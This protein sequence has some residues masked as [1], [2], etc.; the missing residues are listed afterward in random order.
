[1]AK[2]ID[3]LFTLGFSG[4]VGKLMTF[5]RRKKSGNIYVGKRRGASSV[6]PTEE[7][8][9]RRQRFKVALAYAKSAILDPILKAAYA[10]VAGPDQSA[11]N[12]AF[13][14]AY[15]GPEISAVTTLNYLGQPGNTITIRATD[16]FKI[17]SVKVTIRTS[18]GDIIEQ[19][20][21]VLEKNGLDWLY[22]ATA[23]NAALPGTVIIVTATDT[24]AN[25]V[26]KEV[27]L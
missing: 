27:V 13:K 11:F 8:L 10:A 14:D 20:E 19:G 21:A 4:T 15:E 24:P 1:M 23:V 17:T 16:D 7:Q 25:Q 6:P 5:S 12:M 26:V 3:N 18:A 22:T 9:G 2:V